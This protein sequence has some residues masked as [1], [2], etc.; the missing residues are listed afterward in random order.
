MCSHMRR[1]DLAETPHMGFVPACRHSFLHQKTHPASPSI[2]RQ[3]RLGSPRQSCK[4]GRHADR[5]RA[6]SRWRREPSFASSRRE[7]VRNCRLRRTGVLTFSCARPRATMKHFL[8]THTSTRTYARI[9]PVLCSS[10]SPAPAGLY[11]TYYSYR[12]LGATRACIYG[13]LVL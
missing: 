8:A 5:Q 6:V 2:H 11:G 4:P 13:V 12:S 9:R 10:I 1:P 3:G 7:C